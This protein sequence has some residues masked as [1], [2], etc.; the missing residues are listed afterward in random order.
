MNEINILSGEEDGNK[1]ATKMPSFN[2]LKVFFS[3]KKITFSRERVL[4][5]RIIDEEED[6]IY[7]EKSDTNIDWIKQ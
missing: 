7:M 5:T 4:E 3:E 6:D 2:K 1:F